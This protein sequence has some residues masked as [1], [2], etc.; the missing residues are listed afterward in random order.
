MGLVVIATLSLTSVIAWIIE[1][2]RSLV[3]EFRVL[4]GQAANPNLQRTAPSDL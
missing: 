2:E 3:N 1:Y 4:L